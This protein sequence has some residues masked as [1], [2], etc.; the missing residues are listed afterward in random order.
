MLYLKIIIILGMVCL[1][2]F[3]EVGQRAVYSADR[4]GVRVPK[5]ANSENCGSV[6]GAGEEA[7]DLLLCCLLVVL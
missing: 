1:L 4:E 7:P 5:S 2:F 3:Q 6:R